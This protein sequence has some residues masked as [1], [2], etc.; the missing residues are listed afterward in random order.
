MFF[1]KQIN[2]GFAEYYYLLEDGRVLNNNS[3]IYLQRNKNS[4]KL[5]T[6]DGRYKS[7][8]LKDL[9][10]LVFNENYCNDSIESLSGEIWREIPD[11]QK[12]YYC[13]NKGRIK[14]LVGY[15]AIIMNP[16]KT[17]DG[18][19]RVSLYCENGR[20]DLLLHRIVAMCFLSAPPR[21]DYQLHHLDFDRSNC[22]LSNLVW[23]DPKEHRNLHL[24]K[25]KKNNG[26]A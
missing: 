18:Y 3:G 19:L 14:S 12:K 11:T 8:T 21:L 1:I 16:Y 17:K 10:F 26:C 7:I 20:R 25:E 6:A 13:S 23:L 4:Y 22:Q 15:D 2:N 24:E 5:K 9:Y